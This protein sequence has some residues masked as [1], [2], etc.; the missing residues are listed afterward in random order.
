[1]KPYLKFSNMHLFFPTVIACI[2]GIL[3]VVLIIQRALRCKREGVPF[4]NLKGYHFFTPGYDKLKLWGSLVLFVGYILCLNPL[5]FLV[6]SM[7]FITLFNILFAESIDLRALFHK[8]EG[9]VIHAKSLLISVVIGV[10]SSTL[11][12]V[13]FYKIFNITLP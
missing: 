5:G 3:L 7:I 8:G 9:K 1:M 4:I 12:W 6:S 13:L 2:L 10:V 11:I